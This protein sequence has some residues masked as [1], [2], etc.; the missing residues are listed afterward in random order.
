M[1]IL[2]TSD[3][4]LGRS[5][6]REGLL[7]HQAAFVDHLVET[8]RSDR[9]DLV[10]VAG[11]VYDRALPSVDAVAVADDALRRLAGLGVPVVLTAGNHDSARRLGFA[12]DLICA[13]GI[14][15]LTDPARVDRPVWVEDDHGPVAV[16]GLP[17]LEPDVLR[18]PWGLPDRSHEAVAREAMRRVTAHRDGP[19]GGARTIVLAHTWVTGGQPSDSERDITV[20]GVSQ[21]SADVFTGADYVAL[22]H[23]HGRQR[24]SDTVRYSGS[25]L[26]YSFSEA[27]HTKGC[28]LVELGKDGVERVD[29][30]AAPVPRRLARVRGTLEELLASPAHTRHEDH[31]L[32]VTLTDTLRPRAAM[33]RLRTRFPYALLL[34]FAPEGR[35]AATTQWADRLRGRSDRDII[36]DFVEVVRDEPAGPDELALLDAACDA[37]TGARVLEAL[38]GEGGADRRRGTGAPEVL[39]S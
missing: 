36:R 29:F 35:A 38:P 30:V 13:A 12:A 31:W 33:E 5:F 15:L 4:H 17:Y 27:N 34:D 26:P 28:W 1:R 39:A 16:Y 14:H 6:H 32:Q 18:E 11:D 2:H 7:G 3:W 22:G 19:G 9:V 23:L 37:C 21:V 10:V 24:I 25:P 20:G 8:V